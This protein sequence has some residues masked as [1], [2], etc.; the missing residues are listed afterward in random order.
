MVFR[1]LR[2]IGKDTRNA[3]SEGIQQHRAQQQQQQR[4][5]HSFQTPNTAPRTSTWPLLILSS[6]TPSPL[7]A[8]LLNALFTLSLPID[9]SVP[10]SLDILTPTRLAAIYD[11][12]GYPQSDNLPILLHQQ[13]QQACDA[14]TRARVNEGM[15]LYW[16]IFGLEQNTGVRFDGTAV[17]GL[18]RKGFMD[19]M[20]RDGLMYPL[21]Q[22]KSYS[23]LLSRR[24]GELVARAGVE[25]PMGPVGAES[26]M[27]MGEI[28]ATG[29]TETQR[30][31]E[32]GVAVWG[33][34]YRTR[35][36]GGNMAMSGGQG[37]WQMAM[38]TENW[39]HNTV[40]EA[41]TTSFGPLIKTSLVAPGK[42]LIRGGRGGGGF[43]CDGDG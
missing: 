13:A 26:F 27:L 37:R 35:F 3:L 22:A 4:E 9:S 42:M 40:M 20:V 39:R 43:G 1:T 23:A 14:D 28:P 21:G 5:T 18:T 36:G 19:M 34:E 29:H 12:L 7:F 41:L 31:Y 16:R 11:E 38:G 10:P 2:N 8:V 30:V 24:R 6:H 25:F 17:P 32:Q 33:E 15:A